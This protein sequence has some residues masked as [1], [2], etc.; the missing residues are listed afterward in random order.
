MRMYLCNIIHEEA[1]NITKEK[2]EGEIYMEREWEEAPLFMSCK[3]IV[4]LGFKKTAVY[5]WF[6]DETFPP[7]ICNNGI[8]V[9]KYRLRE[10]LENLQH[11][12]RNIMGTG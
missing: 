8:R 7:H 3:D 10:W 11:N 12:S 5:C 6:K 1:V 4:K 9:N 2:Y